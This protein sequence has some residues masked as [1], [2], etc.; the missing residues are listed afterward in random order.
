MQLICW[1]SRVGVQ[2]LGV[3][4]LCMVMREISLGFVC[5]ASYGH[6][7]WR[8]RSL[9]SGLGPPLEEGVL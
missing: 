4:G 7:T 8:S 5:A 1:G 6:I 9:E 3:L 2:S